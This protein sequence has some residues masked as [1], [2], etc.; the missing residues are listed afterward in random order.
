MFNRREPNLTEVLVCPL[1][2]PVIDEH[3]ENSQEVSIGLV[4]YAK[5]STST[6]KSAQ[7]S[8]DQRRTMIISGDQRA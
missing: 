8:V 5:R 2:E 1:G 3:A 6:R 4:P 7:H